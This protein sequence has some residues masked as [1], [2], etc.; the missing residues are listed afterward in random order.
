MDIGRAYTA[1][2]GQLDQAVDPTHRA[3][4]MPRFC[5][6]LRL[7]PS[8]VNLKVRKPCSTVQPRVWLS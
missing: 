1:I 5:S 4:L 8:D 6:S 7:G 2:K 3:D